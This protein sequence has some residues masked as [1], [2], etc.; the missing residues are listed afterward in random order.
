CR[1]L[2]RWQLVEIAGGDTMATSPLRIQERVL[3]YLA[4]VHCLDERLLAFVRPVPQPAHLAPSHGAIAE[5]IAALWSRAARGPNLPIVELCGGEIA[6]KRPV[7]AVASAL[8]GLQL[9]TVPAW[10]LPS[11]A[12]EVESFLR[13]WE[14]EAV[15]SSSA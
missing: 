8:I 12:V 6:D 10:G 7:A 5:Q 1:P 13:L 15:L 2:R 9:H 14:R 3:H 4:G 11:S